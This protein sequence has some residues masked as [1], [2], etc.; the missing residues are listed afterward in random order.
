M[1]T[2]IYING[3][4]YDC[5]TDWILSHYGYK[6]QKNFE[7]P[8]VKFLENNKPKNSP[9]ARYYSDGG[10]FWSDR[11]IVTCNTGSEM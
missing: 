9:N 11:W 4:K 6:E 7:Y 1:R 3:D 8:F 5:V 2:K 10:I